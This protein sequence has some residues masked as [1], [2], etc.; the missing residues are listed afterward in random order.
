M[1]PKSF[2]YRYQARCGSWLA[3]IFGSAHSRILMSS[4][5]IIHPQ[6]GFGEVVPGERSSAGITLQCLGGH[7]CGGDLSNRVGGCRPS[8]AGGRNCECAG[9]AR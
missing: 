5:F 2:M 7:R 9:A 4:S 8:S 1:A 6:C 3:S